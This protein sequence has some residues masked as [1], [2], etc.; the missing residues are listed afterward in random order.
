MHF[1]TRFSEYITW[2]CRMKFVGWN[3]F[4]NDEYFNVIQLYHPQEHGMCYIALTACVTR[5]TACVTARV[6]ARVTASN[7][8]LHHILTG[9][10]KTVRNSAWLLS[11]TFLS[12][13]IDTL[14]NS[15]ELDGSLFVGWGDCLSGSVDGPGTSSVGTWHNLLS[16]CRSKFRYF[17]IFWLY[18][19]NHVPLNNYSKIQVF[20]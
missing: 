4:R 12:K 7:N 5:V 18:S 10:T 13:V 14:S 16:D 2:Q 8:N 20:I 9:L 17:V 3:F 6:T 15:T 1:Y 19:D 11:S